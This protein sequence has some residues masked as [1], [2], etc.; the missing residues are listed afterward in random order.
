MPIPRGERQ[1]SSVE[2]KDANALAVSQIKG[3]KL[4]IWALYLSIFQVLLR[5]IVYGFDARNILLISELK[6]FNLPVF[7]QLITNTR[8]VASFRYSVEACASIFVGY[9]DYLLGLSVFSHQ[10]VAAC[11]M[12]GFNVVR[13]IFS[14]FRATSFYDF[15]NRTSFYF[16]E[17]L[18]EFFFMPTFVRFFKHNINLRVLFATFMSVFI[19]NVLYHFFSADI[20]YVHSEGMTTA[21]K[22]YQG[23]IFYCFCLFVLIGFSQLH[24]LR[25]GHA[26]AKW[27]SVVL[28]FATNAVLHTFDATRAKYSLQSYCVFYEKIFG[29]IWGYK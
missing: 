15:W 3:I 11:R 9:F 20:F 14:P 24:V 7:D 17:L 4:L 27:L 19:G 23:Y 22:N 18:V 10:I 16:K 29:F 6:S 28:V 1:A 12:S 13:N 8:G 2:A 25:A 21:I 5:H 26:K